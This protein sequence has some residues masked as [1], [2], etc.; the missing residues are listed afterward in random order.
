MAI[1]LSCV[2][3]LFASLGYPFATP[4]HRDI[5]EAAAVIGN[6]ER[7]RKSIPISKRL[8]HN[9]DIH[10]IAEKHRTLYEELIT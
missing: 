5:N 2:S 8:S 4:S 9:Y 1:R 7:L 6:E 3:L 10:S